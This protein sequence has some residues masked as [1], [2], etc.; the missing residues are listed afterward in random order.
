M[1]L[2]GNFFELLYCDSDSDIEI[3]KRLLDSDSNVEI[4]KRLLD[5]VSN[6]NA[7]SKKVNSVFLNSESINNKNIY[8][9]K[10]YRYPKNLKYLIR[11]KYQKV[12]RGQPIKYVRRVQ[13]YDEM[14]NL[15]S[16]LQDAVNS[17]QNLTLKQILVLM[18][19]HAMSGMAINVIHDK[20]QQKVHKMSVKIFHDRRVFNV[21]YYYWYD[22]KY[23]ELLINEIF[24]S[25]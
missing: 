11:Q 24:D 17:K 1:S 14:G 23:I 4:E 9:K 25:Y 18:N 7:Q 8:R 6:T 22:L 5:S 2:S 13:I 20:I 3:E 10:I 12:R 16:S 15:P 21:S 19:L